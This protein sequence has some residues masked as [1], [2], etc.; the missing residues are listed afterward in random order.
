MLTICGKNDLLITLAD[1][2]FCSLDG[3]I[4]LITKADCDDFFKNLTLPKKN[5]LII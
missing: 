3:M 2:P 4:V 1:K 5:L